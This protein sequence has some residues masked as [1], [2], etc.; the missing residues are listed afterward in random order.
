MSSVH[1]LNI[2]PSGFCGG[3]RLVHEKR[4]DQERGR[5]IAKRVRLLLRS[6]TE[7]WI[8]D[9]LLYAVDLHVRYWIF[10]KIGVA[11]TTGSSS[12]SKTTSF[13]MTS[14]PLSILAILF[15]KCLTICRLM[16]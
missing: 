14:E 3:L 6:V 11:A 7:V 16:E 12:V 5:A 15:C 10:T 4:S 1:M 2:V 9:A 13:M 8:S